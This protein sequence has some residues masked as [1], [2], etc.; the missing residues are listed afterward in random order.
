[1]DPEEIEANND[2]AGEGQQ[3]FYRSTDRQKHMLGGVQEYDL[4][5]D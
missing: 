4:S 5:S 1:M 3:Q 2:C